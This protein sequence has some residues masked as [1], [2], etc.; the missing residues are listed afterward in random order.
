MGKPIRVRRGKI[1]IVDGRWVRVV[2][3]FKGE[4]T[5]DQFT[6]FELANFCLK[7]ITELIEGGREAVLDD[8]GWCE[9]CLNKY[10]VQPS[11]WDV[12]GNR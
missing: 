5:V 7:K 4:E 9:D 6:V 1:Q 11:E 3:E 10:S 12:E 8:E 2:T